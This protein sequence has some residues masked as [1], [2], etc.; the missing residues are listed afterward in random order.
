MKRTLQLMP[1]GWPIALRDCPPGLFVFE[2]AVGLKSEYGNG[3]GGNGCYCDTGEMFWGG[4][5]TPDKRDSLM[6]Q[7]VIAKWV[8]VD[9]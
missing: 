9:E 5:A 8:E 3:N 7:P 1:E 6:V 4:T 2:D